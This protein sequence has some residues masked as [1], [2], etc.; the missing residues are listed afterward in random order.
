MRLPRLSLRA[1]LLAALLAVTTVFLLAL[2]GVALVVVGKRLGADFDGQLQVNASHQ[3]RQLIG[4]S[5]VYAVYYS[6]ASGRTGL[7]SVPS[8]TG[9]QLQAW[10]A[11]VMQNRH[12]HP[13]VGQLTPFTI[14]LDN[15]QLALLLVWRG[16]AARSEANQT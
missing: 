6:R 13:S 15:G 3:V 2:G 7:L 16:V 4:T 11:G 8:Q 5:E 12:G 14:N 1:R 10:R 9:H